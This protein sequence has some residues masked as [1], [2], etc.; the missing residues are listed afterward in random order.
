MNDATRRLVLLLLAGFASAPL[1]ADDGDSDPT[2][3]DDG[4][5]TYTVSPPAAIGE[6]ATAVAS[7]A[8]GSLLIGGWSA[9]PGF[10]DDFAVVKYLRTGAPDLAF[11]S[12]GSRTIDFGTSDTLWDLVVQA[13]GRIVLVGSSYVDDDPLFHTYPALARLTPGG[14]LDP[15]FGVGGLLRIDTPPWP[16]AEIQVGER[17][18]V[19]TTGK[20]VLDGRCRLCP[21]NDDWRVFVV[22]LLADGTLDTGF[23]GDGWYVLPVD[24]DNLS[25]RALALDA[26]N[27]I[28]VGAILPDPDWTISLWRL[29]PA[30]ALDPTFGDGDG[31]V[32]T[33]LEFGNPFDLDVSAEDGRIYLR[34]SLGVWRFL[35]SGAVDSGYGDDGVASL[36]G[37]DE[38][39]GVLD[40]ELQ[41]DGKLVAAGVI[42]PNGA[43]AGDFFL[44]RLLPD[45]S[46]DPT[47]AGN[48]VRRVSFDL[49]PDGLDYAEAVTLSG[50]RLVAVGFATTGGAGES[51]WA[52][53]RAESA[54]IFTDGFERGSVA[55]WT[56]N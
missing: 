10:G 40:A 52:I 11:G 47:F 36:S 42:N 37:Y 35:A 44:A 26:A 4:Q 20:L 18:A 23:D 5:T 29:T 34:A 13:D 21:S 25:H 48:G 2:F 3:S 19:T 7:L 33:P 45:G 53:L 50:G 6:R 22:R 32:D 46:P 1:V 41:S 56:G 55:S 16:G 17:V 24:L 14:D 8:D 49:V 39:S 28:L 54:L 43:D 30:G 51:N 15:T 31:R 12:L 9:G 27:R 38:G